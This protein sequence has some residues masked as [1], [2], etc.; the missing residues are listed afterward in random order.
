MRDKCALARGHAP[1]VRW[2]VRRARKGPAM[3]IEP[4]TPRPDPLRPRPG[5][6]RRRAGLR[7]EGRRACPTRPSS[8]PSPIRP[9]ST[10]AP[11]SGSGTT[12]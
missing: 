8:R 4:P 9:P 10:A 6:R 5:D 11:R 7:E 2:V 1:S 3:T 12:V